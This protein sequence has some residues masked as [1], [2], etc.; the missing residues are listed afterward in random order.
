MDG[1]YHP[2]LVDGAGYVLI[3]SHRSSALCT[4][5]PFPDALH[6]SL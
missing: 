4:M 2:V 5:E 1:I 3:K 6:H